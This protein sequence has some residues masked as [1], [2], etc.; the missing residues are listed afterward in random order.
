MHGGLRL[1][2]LS[3]SQFNS[4]H[5]TPNEHNVIRVVSKNTAGQGPNSKGN[6]ENAVHVI[7]QNFERQN[8]A[9]AKVNLNQISAKLIQG[10]CHSANV[11]FH[12]TPSDFHSS[13][14]P[15]PTYTCRNPT[16][17]NSAAWL[18]SFNRQIDGRRTTENRQTSIQL[19][20]KQ[21][22]R[23][24]LIRS[25]APTAKRHVML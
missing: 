5:P 9:P 25:V 17:P 13:P 6:K 22:L 23:D 21:C 19:H 20:M 1:L 14:L 10:T 18:I 2:F 24:A 11:V 12:S 8:C 4:H 16:V 3:Y 15:S 7:L